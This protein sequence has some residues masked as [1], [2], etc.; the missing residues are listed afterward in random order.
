M[1]NFQKGKR[2]QRGASR[3]TEREFQ[4]HLDKVVNDV[5]IGMG[6]WNLNLSRMTPMQI[7]DGLIDAVAHIILPMFGRMPEEDCHVVSPVMRA[8]TFQKVMT[9]ALQRAGYGFRD[10]GSPEDVAEAIAADTKLEEMMHRHTGIRC[11]GGL[12][13]FRSYLRDALCL[14]FANRASA[15]TPEAIGAMLRESFEVFGTARHAHRM[16]V[17]TELK[18]MAACVAQINR[19]EVPKCYWNN[20]VES[21]R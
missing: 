16:V 8:Y 6:N 13:D 17:C 2:G 15:T 1:R 12:G 11:I 7:A 20:L 21:W 5:C 18:K 10:L 19:V 14:V 9:Y 4:K 3:D